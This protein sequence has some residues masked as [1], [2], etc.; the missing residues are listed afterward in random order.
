MTKKLIKVILVIFGAFII[1]VY[2]L[3]DGG[4]GGGSGSRSSR[5]TARPSTY[6]IIYRISGS[7]SKASLTYE[8]ASGNTEQQDVRVPWELELEVPAGQF[9]YISAQN[10]RDSGS[11]RCEIVQ[12]GKVVEEASSSGAYVIASCSGSAGR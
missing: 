4:G 7:T 9:L 12:D 5:P 1:I 3:G 2:L 11:I 8:N 10:D 6:D